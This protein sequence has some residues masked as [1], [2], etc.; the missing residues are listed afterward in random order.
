MYDDHMYCT[1]GHCSD[2]W[3]LV[4]WPNDPPG[5]VCGIDHEEEETNDDQAIPG[6]SETT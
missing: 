2:C 1:L 3:C 4:V 6:D 5:P